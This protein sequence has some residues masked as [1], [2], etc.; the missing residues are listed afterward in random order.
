VK[1]GTFKD[2]LIAKFLLALASTMIFGS[3]SHGT[4]GHILL[5]DGS[6]NLQN[7][8]PVFKDGQS[9]RHVATDDQ[10]VRKCWFRGPSGFHDRILI[11][12]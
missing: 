2:W 3:K 11:S 10:S 7:S 9:Q 4:H 5:S 8:P 12:V 6:G 1:L